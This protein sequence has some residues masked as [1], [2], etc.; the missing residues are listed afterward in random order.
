MFP[1][2]SNARNRLRT[3]V[4]DKEVCLRTAPSRRDDIGR[5]F[6]VNRMACRNIHARVIAQRAL[7]ETAI[8]HV[9][10]VFFPFTMD[11]QT[12]SDKML[13]GKFLLGDGK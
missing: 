8:V 9:P 5:Y 6:R 7:Y 11:A 2:I 4:G 1:I 13:E 12:L 10:Q 3:W